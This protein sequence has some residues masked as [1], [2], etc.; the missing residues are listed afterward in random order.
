MNKSRIFAFGDNEVTHFDN[1]L[2]RKDEIELSNTIS[3]NK[4]GA[5]R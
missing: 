5:K 1:Y 3:F 2:F 4:T